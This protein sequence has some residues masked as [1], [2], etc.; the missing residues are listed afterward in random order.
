M[1][2]KAGLSIGRQKEAFRA[3]AL[4]STLKVATIM[5]AQFPGWVTLIYV[6]SFV[7]EFKTFQIGR[8]I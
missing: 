7:V 5:G 3:G 1:L 8:L 4:K 6:C 2:T